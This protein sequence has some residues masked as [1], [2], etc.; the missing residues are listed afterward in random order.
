MGRWA[1]IGLA[2]ALCL[3]AVPAWAQCGVFKTWTL[4][5]VLE[6]ADLNGAF[7]RTVTANVASCTA[8]D[9]GS[10]GQMQV[11]VDPYPASS[12]SLA[13]TVQGELERLRY[14]LKA[15]VGKSQWYE[16]I[17]NS[18]AKD[19][20]KHWGATYTNFYEIADPSPPGP[21]ILSLYAKDD[22][23]GV[24][25][26]AYKDPNGI[27][28]TLTGPSTSYGSAITINFLARRNPGTPNTKIDLSAD[29]ISVAGFIK[30]AFTA[31][32]DATTTGANAL[33]TG[34][35]SASTLYYVWAI[36]NPSSNTFAGLLSLSETAPTMPIG[37]TQKRL[38]GAFA[39]DGAT[40]FLDGYQRDNIFFYSVPITVVSGV[41]VTSA[42]A[43]SLVGK[44][45]AA[46][47]RAA[48]LT[49]SSPGNQ[50]DM[51]LHW[52]SWSGAPTAL[53]TPIFA[54]NNFSTGM[55]VRLPTYGT[56]RATIYYATST[57]FANGF[58]LTGWEMQWPD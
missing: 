33:D 14:Q 17:D 34:T 10:V 24:T 51:G 21:N 54:L 35:L 26:L 9:S 8:G 39:T 25:V 52:Q 57:G 48:W 46:T 1:R 3:W 7:G 15:V 23:F 19:V 42:T 20:A 2:G 49:L 29:R 16:V 38:L 27:V 6:S 31:T 41:T 55:P 37:Y 18:L 13:T 32:I 30:A 11:V 58:V 45:P 40:L 43:V 28:N 50:I 12:E 44:V 53:L 47:V 56:P 5:E 36:V 22:G 4:N